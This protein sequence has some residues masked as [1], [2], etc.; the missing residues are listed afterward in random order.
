MRSTQGDAQQTFFAV[1]SFP[2]Q[3]SGIFKWYIRVV[4]GVNESRQKFPYINGLGV[5]D[6]IPFWT[7]PPSQ[8][9]SP[10]AIDEKPRPDPSSR[11]TPG[12]SGYS[13]LWWPG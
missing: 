8:Q 4:S 12:E 7:L 6:F 9:F 1:F 2:K 5:L 3:M 10:L 11:D 13:G